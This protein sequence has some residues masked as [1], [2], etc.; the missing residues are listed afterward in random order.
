MGVDR[1]GPK[2]IPGNFEFS[3]I[4]NVVGR[5]SILPTWC[6]MEVRKHNFSWITKLLRR[7]L[8]FDLFLKDGII[9]V[10]NYNHSKR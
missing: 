3:T 1:V 9:M 10:Y 4:F 8:D 6:C 5:G 7:C 2:K